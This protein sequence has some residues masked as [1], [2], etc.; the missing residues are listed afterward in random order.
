[1]IATNTTTHTCFHIHKVAL[2]F[3]AAA[4][5][6]FLFSQAV[7]DSSACVVFMYWVKDYWFTT[8]VSSHVYFNRTV[9]LQGLL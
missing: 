3:L 2:L 5:R 4:P 7:D 8:Y 9:K 1:M 6:A